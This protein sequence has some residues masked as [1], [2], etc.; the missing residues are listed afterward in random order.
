MFQVRFLTVAISNLAPAAALPWHVAVRDA[1]AAVEAPAL[2]AAAVASSE[3]PATC[4]FA[5]IADS[6]RL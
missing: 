2:V 5:A 6:D 4:G 3:C 1:A